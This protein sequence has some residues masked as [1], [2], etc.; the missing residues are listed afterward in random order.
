MLSVA[1]KTTPEDL[2]GYQLCRALGRGG[3]GEVWE[4]QA[5]GGRHVALKFLPYANSSAASEEVRSIQLVRQ[6]RH[7]GLVRIEKVWCCPGYLVIAM[8]LADGSLTDLA[9]AYKEEFQ[10]PIPADYSCFLLMQAADALDFLNGFRHKVRDRRVSFQHC[11]I[12]PGNLLIFGETVKLC[13]FGL[14]TRV[15]SLCKNRRPAGTPEYSAPEVLRSRI[16]EATDQF[17][18]AVTYCELRGD[19]LPFPGMPEVYSQNYRRPPPDLSMLSAVEQPIV[20]R[21]LSSN[22]TERWPTCRAFMA[23]LERVVG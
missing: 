15:N 4:A 1:Y 11:D 2:P 10:T 16:S 17:S 22:P 23:E 21:A 7:R 3:F 6:L 14:T 12:K 8:E 9:R 5:E 13:D 20:Q 18:L 19:R